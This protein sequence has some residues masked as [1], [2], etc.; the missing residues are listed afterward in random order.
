[1]SSSKLADVSADLLNNQDALN[2][3]LIVSVGPDSTKI[4]SGSLY[5][6]PTTYLV[7]SRSDPPLHT[8]SGFLNILSDDPGAT[9]TG[10]FR[11]VSLRQLQ[12]CVGGWG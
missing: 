7:R 5:F 2:A 10:L 6:N 9:H 4:D 11:V 12:E 1:L 3:N 8:G